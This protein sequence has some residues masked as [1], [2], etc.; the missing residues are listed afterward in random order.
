LLAQGLIL[1]LLLSTEWVV[2]LGPGIFLVGEKY[3]FYA[4]TLKFQ[5]TGQRLMVICFGLEC[6]IASRLL[7][8]SLWIVATLLR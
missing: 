2:H 4:A 5:S 8:R 7:A 3:D 6:A 1:D